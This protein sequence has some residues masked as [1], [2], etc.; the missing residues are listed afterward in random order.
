M[1]SEQNDRR[2]MSLMQKLSVPETAKPPWSLITAALAVLVMLV[3]LILVG[4]ALSSLLLDSQQISPFLLM[5]SW[6]IGM[7][8][9][10]LFVIVNRR[11]SPQSWNALRM[12]KGNL[13]M[14]IVLLIGV[15]L[16]L[17]VD[18]IV[19][20]AS[21]QFLPAPQIYGLATTGAPGVLVA[22]ALLVFLQ[23]VAETLVFQAVLLPSLRWA[24][25][26]WRG[27][28][29]TCLLYTLLHVLVFFAPYQNLYHGLWYGLAL[30]FL[31]CLV[32][33]LFKVFTHSSHSVLVARV[34]AGLIFLLTG[35]VLTGL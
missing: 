15:A 20:L 34:S 22:A 30:P 2:E 6:T 4:P 18:L 25:G 9:T 21:G 24:L 31:T 23:P 7:G 14:P 27:L 19:S 29:A 26:A 8:V 33:S 1:S 5:L 35:M 12:T 17:F 3:S 10:V 32:F 28:I 16:A 11:S 13:P